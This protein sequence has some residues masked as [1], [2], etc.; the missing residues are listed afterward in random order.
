VPPPT[1]RGGRGATTAIGSSCTHRMER[2]TPSSAFGLERGGVPDRRWTAMASRRAVVRSIVR[3][4]AAT[5]SGAPR[6]DAPGHADA[7]PVAG[8]HLD[9]REALELLD[10]RRA[11]RER[12]VARPDLRALPVVALHR[13]ELIHRGGR[14]LLDA[15]EVPRMQHRERVHEPVG[16]RASGDREA[17]VD[18][19][20]VVDAD[21]CAEPPARLQPGTGL[22]VAHWTRDPDR[23]ELLRVALVRA[24]DH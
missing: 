14:T 6:A 12:G 7:A 4:A 17:G 5:R 9:R 18:D 15:R 13:Y 3:S 21:A 19:P 10:R 24:P 22:A 11:E 20:P 23:A 2:M 1:P 16:L 8:D